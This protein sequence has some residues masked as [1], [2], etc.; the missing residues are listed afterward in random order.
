LIVYPDLSGGEVRERVMHAKLFTTS[1]L[2]SPT[3][4]HEKDKLGR[5]D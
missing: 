5:E 3:L 4:L 1:L 2:L